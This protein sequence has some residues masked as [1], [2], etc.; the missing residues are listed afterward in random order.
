MKPGL[1]SD[2]APAVSDPRHRARGRRRTGRRARRRRLL[3]GHGRHHL[4]AQRAGLGSRPRDVPVRR[5]GRRHPRA[6]LPA[7]REL[8]L[9]GHQGRHGDRRDP[10]AAHQGDPRRARGGRAERA[11][12]ARGGQRD[13]VP[14]GAGGRDA[15]DDRA[16]AGQRHQPRV[17]GGQG[18]VDPGAPTKGQA[19]FVAPSL[20]LYT[21]SGSALYRGSL[22]SSV[23]GAHRDVVNVV[24]LEYYVRGVIAREMPASWRAQALRAQAVAARSLRRLRARLALGC[25]LRRG[26]HHPLAGLRRPRRGDHGHQR[27]RDGDQDRGPVLRRQARLHPVLLQQRRLDDPGVDALPRG[28]GRPLRPGAYLDRQR[29]LGGAWSGPGPRSARPPA[30][31]WSSAT[32]TAPGAV[33]W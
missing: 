13:V 18:E 24:P 2:D 33:A 16:D 17:G 31:R 12:R 14:L 19:E 23:D 10:G 15:L 3:P 30:C 11:E 29:H 5:A 32:G 22:R 21:P 20:R 25:A 27:R 9:P 7:D 8:L 26:R 4:L 6:D 28:E 1:V